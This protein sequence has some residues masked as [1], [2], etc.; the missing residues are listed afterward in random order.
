M[1]NKFKRFIAAATLVSLAATQTVSA[2]TQSLCDTSGYTLGFFN[3]VW[4]TVKGATDGMTAL[5]V[6]APSTYNGKPVSGELFYN[7][8]GCGPLKVGCL[9]DIAETF[10]QRANELD[11]SGAL[12]THFEYFW[13]LMLGQGQ[14][15]LID[16]VVA[17]FTSA[18]DVFTAMRNSL[19]AAIATDTSLLLS[20]PPT[21]ADYAA[22]NAR[23]DALATEGQMLMLVAHS[24][25]NLFVNHAYDHVAPEVGTSSVSVVHIAPAS[26]TLRGDYVLANIDL[27]INALRAEGGNTVQPVNLTIATSSADLSGHTLVGTY[28]D[29]SRDG[30]AKVVSMMNAALGQL[31]PPAQAA[32]V[33]KGSFT[34]TMTWSG[35]GDEDLHVIEPTGSHVY[36]ANRQG[37]V[38]YLDTDNTVGYGPEHYYATCDANVLQ[39]GQYQL[40]LVDFRAADNE[41]ATIQVATNDGV[42]LTKQF[43]TGPA[44]GGITPTQVMTVN[45]AKDPTTGQF[46][47]SA[48]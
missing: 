38:G 45:V 5:Q 40:G 15:S 14:F 44:T 7:H 21:E 4:N 1:N 2:A 30:R 16:R 31:S 35:T 12:A 46:S 25:G 3:G 36:F 42:L 20:N 41:T 13:E 29:G 33:A 26:P 28:L 17:L 37:Q 34:V 39:P 27:V 43:A 48:Q 9:Q 10:V 22:H 11:T 19:V 6:A 8:T 47:F 24:Q 23:L 32:S 18:G